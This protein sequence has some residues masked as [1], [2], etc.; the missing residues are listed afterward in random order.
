MFLGMGTLIPWNV[1]LL[2]ADFLALLCPHYGVGTISSS[3]A[4]STIITNVLTI[5]LMVKLGIQNKISARARIAGTFFAQAAVFLAGVIASLSL[6]RP[7]G[8]ALSRAEMTRFNLIVAIGGILGACDAIVQG[9]LIGYASKISPG[10]AQSLATGQS[11]AGVGVSIFRMLSQFAALKGG[12]SPSAKQLSQQQVFA[13]ARK[14]S[15]IFYMGASCALLVSALLFLNA[16]KIKP[17]ADKVSQIRID[18]VISSIEASD[19]TLHSSIGHGLKRRL[20]F[21]NSLQKVRQNL[22]DGLKRRLSFTAH[23]LT[24][25]AHEAASSHLTVSSKP[26]KTVPEKL[27]GCS[28][29]IVTMF[30]VSVM[31]FPT[32]A[33][34]IQSSSPDPN[35]WFPMKVCLVWGIGELLGRSTAEGKRVSARAIALPIALR[36]L[37]IPVFIALRRSATLFGALHDL[38]AMTAVFAMASSLGFFSSVMTAY[39]SSKAT[40]HEREEAGQ[41]V[42]FSIATGLTLGSTMAAILNRLV[43]SS[44]AP[45]MLLQ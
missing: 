29:A 16:E 25:P 19:S 42:Q 34:T 6:S 35:R 15:I 13:L 43:E 39:A 8:G 10:Y 22:E 5:T 37:L 38:A 2:S 23:Q 40:V 21:T 41:Y 4:L 27:R 44:R 3:L 18:S 32:M 1:L 26:K 17:I 20:S 24:A 9:G 30:A 14:G 7:S 12:A 45:R 33:T 28:I 36:A 31:V 11:L